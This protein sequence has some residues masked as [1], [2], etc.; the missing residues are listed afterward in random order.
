LISTVGM[1]VTPS[2]ALDLGAMAFEFITGQ[3]L[4]P[5]GLAA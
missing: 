3:D 1:A 5:F 2:I 4:D